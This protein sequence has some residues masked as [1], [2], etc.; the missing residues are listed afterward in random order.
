MV[1]G[2]DMPISQTGL[3]VFGQPR[4]MYLER[5]RMMM[6]MMRRRRRR[7]FIA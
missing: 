1:Q 6:M 7:R 3:Q 4:V 5:R 2:I